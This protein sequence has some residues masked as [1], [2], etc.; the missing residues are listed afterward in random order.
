V[1][2][3]VAEFMNVFYGS[4]VTGMPEVYRRI[5][6][7]ARCYDRSWDRV[8]SRVRSP[9]YGN[10][11]GRG[12]GTT[13][14]DRTLPPP[15]LPSLPGLDFVPVYAGRYARLVDEARRMALENDVLLHLLH[16]YIH[17][18]D[19]NRYSLEVFLSIAELAGHHNRMIIGM[20]G[21]ENRLGSARAAAER[22]RPEDAVEQLQ[23]AYRQAQAVVEAR[24]RTFEFLK[25][26]WEKSR[27]PKGQEVNGRKFLHVLDDTKDHRA[28]RRAD[29]SY[30]I[31]PEESI[32]LE[33]WMKQL[34]AVAQAYGKSNSMAVPEF[35]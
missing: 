1:E 27:F 17:K 21:I 10:S 32:E 29:L 12:I 34:A 9:G 22:G 16:E 26:V 28:D 5:Q 35:R 30:L 24:K 33:H 15:A 7:Q 25:T 19:R 11:E 3:N 31:A 2:Q 8:V 6:A 4:R 20:A 23:G 13:R 18:A 14:F